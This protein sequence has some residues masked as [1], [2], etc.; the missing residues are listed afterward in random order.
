MTFKENT[1]PI[2]DMHIGCISILTRDLEKYSIEE[3]EEILKLTNEYPERIVLDEIE[4]LKHSFY[5]K[6]TFRST[7]YTL[8]LHKAQYNLIDSCNDLIRYLDSFDD[9][10][11]KEE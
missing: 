10:E 7:V 3:L 4:Y 8:I 9:T 2:E 11:T 1:D 6:D 5:S